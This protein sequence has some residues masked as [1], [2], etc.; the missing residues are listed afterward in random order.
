MNPKAKLLIPFVLGAVI[1]LLAA[2]DGA[3]AKD[4]PLMTKEEL[5]KAIADG[6]VTILDARTGRDW[7]SSEFKIQG[8]VRADPKKVDDWADSHPKDGVVVVYCA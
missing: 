4:V 3:V 1:V 7:G 8:A 2:L 5:K 6:P